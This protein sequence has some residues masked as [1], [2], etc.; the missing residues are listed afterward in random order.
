MAPQPKRATDAPV[1]SQNAIIHADVL[2]AL[3]FCLELE[4]LLLEG[5]MLITSS[6]AALQQIATACQERGIVFGV[7]IDVADAE[8]LPRSEGVILCHY[9]HLYQRIRR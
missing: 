3:R 6:D 8:R 2:T 7:G 4:S 9:D 5:C 1:F